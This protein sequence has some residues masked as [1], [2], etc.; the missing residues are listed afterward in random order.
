M[1][2][3][4]DIYTIVFTKEHD[5]WKKGVY[6]M[7]IALYII[8]TL[9]FFLGTGRKRDKG[10]FREIDAFIFFLISI[11]LMC[12]IMIIESLNSLKQEF[13]FKPK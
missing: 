6:A 3:N 12:S 7:R 5:K 8:D 2:K 10:S 4:A 11:I 9:V 13:R 1:I